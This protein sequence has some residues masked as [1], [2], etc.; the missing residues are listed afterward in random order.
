MLITYE[1]SKKIKVNLISG[2]AYS[3]QE[4]EKKKISHKLFKLSNLKY[5]LVIGLIAFFARG[6][7]RKYKRKG[8]L[9]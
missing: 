6:F 8:K 3:T 4:V 1:N 5:L 9:F 7:Y 2:Q